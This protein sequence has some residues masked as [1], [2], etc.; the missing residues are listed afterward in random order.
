MLLAALAAPALAGCADSTQLRNDRAE[1]SARRDVASRERQRVTR[2]NPQV[3]VTGATRVSDSRSTAIVVDL[4]SSADA[5]LTDVPVS[6][7]VRRRD[8]RR[9]LLNARPGLDWFQTHVA[10]IPARGTA[11]WVFRTRRPVPPGRPFA[12]AG[13]LPEPT[14]S[15]AGSL[16]ALHV[17]SQPATAPGGRTRARHE[18]VEGP[19]GRAAGV[20]RPP[21][22]RPLGGGRSY[23][24]RPA[25][26]WAGGDGHGAADRH[27]VR[28][29]APR[30]GAAHD[31]PM[32]DSR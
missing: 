32:R 18:R 2:P 4:R 15:T 21:P 5:P 11:I 19:A 8:G 10:A 23:D 28:R 3:R 1:L 12:V 14:L 29:E 22:R 31:L 24:G 9:A 16:P 25:R 6:V 13:T 26:A 17:A 27:P 7:G 20:R 30:R